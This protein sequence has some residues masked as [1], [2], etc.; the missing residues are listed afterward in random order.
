MAEPLTRSLSL[1]LVHSSL[2]TSHTRFGMSGAGMPAFIAT[3]D[4]SATELAK[5]TNL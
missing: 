1:A 3:L 2:A 4:G 5:E